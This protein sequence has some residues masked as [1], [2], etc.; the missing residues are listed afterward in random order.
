ML[1]N[2]DWAIIP[3]GGRQIY[4]GVLSCDRDRSTSHKVAGS[5]GRVKNIFD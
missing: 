4:K 1:E 2:G 3:W 5:L